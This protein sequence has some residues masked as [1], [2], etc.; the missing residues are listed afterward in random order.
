MTDIFVQL[1]PVL[2]PF[3][4]QLTP[5][6][7]NYLYINKDFITSNNKWHFGEKYNAHNNK[8]F[9]YKQEIYI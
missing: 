6:N 7:I 9:N 4:E 3:T 5:G 8:S 1:F 2:F